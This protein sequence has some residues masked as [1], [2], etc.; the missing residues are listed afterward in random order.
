MGFCSVVEV[1]LGFQQ[2]L[3]LGPSIERGVLHHGLAN[4][5]R[6]E[7]TCDRGL[8]VCGCVGCREQQLGVYVCVFLVGSFLAEVPADFLSG[9]L[10]RSDSAICDCG[11]AMIL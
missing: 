8:D 11:R 9:S 6:G 5:C 10:T 4:P 7:L 2:V 1:L 3:L